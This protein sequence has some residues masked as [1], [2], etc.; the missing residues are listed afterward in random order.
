MNPTY[1]FK[2]GEFQGPLQKILEL[3]EE[4]KLEITRLSLAEITA[5]FFKYLQSL[6]KTDPRIIADFV[7]VAA[8]L[9][10]LK[11]HALLPQMPFTEE[12]EKE[13]LDLETRLKIYQE[14]KTTIQHIKSRWLNEVAYSRDY[15]AGIPPGFYLNQKVIPEDLLKKI[16]S[17]SEELALI[18]PQPD[19]IKIKLINLEEKINELILRIDK[20]LKTSFNEIAKN[21]EKPEIVVLFLALLHLLKDNLIK[22]NQQDKF[23]DIEIISLKNNNG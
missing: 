18:F 23:A 14:L 6:E 10:L 19:S 15:L 11:S 21:K 13:I 4:K 9:I 17:L 16:I 22:I 7:A 20:T 1:E 5:D 2:I 12:E 8:K 3:I